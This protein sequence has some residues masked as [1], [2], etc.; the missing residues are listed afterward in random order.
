MCGRRGKKG[1]ESRK[2]QFTKG[3]I[4]P[5]LLVFRLSF[6]QLF[7]T[8]TT[9]KY[10]DTSRVV[11]NFSTTAFLVFLQKPLLMTISKQRHERVARFSL[12]WITPDTRSYLHCSIALPFLLQHSK[13]ADQVSS[14]P[15][16]RILGFESSINVKRVLERPRYNS[17]MMLL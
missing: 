4:N 8:K 5:F 6:F 17:F 9:C 11:G 7:L 1:T 13:I 15:P 3:K 10:S 2:L 14:P 16:L 12:K